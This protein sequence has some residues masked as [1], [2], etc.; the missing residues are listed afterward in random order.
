MKIGNVPVLNQ[1]LS[2]NESVNIVAF[3][4]TLNANFQFLLQY[5]QYH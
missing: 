4:Q 5:F 3:D 2:I 1:K